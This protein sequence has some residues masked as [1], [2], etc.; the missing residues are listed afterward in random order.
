MTSMTNITTVIPDFAHVSGICDRCANTNANQKYGAKINCDSHDASTQ[1][2][3]KP[4]FCYSCWDLPD[5]NQMN[6]TVRQTTE[7]GEIRRQIGSEQRCCCLEW[8][9]KEIHQYSSS[10]S[11]RC[12]NLTLTAEIQ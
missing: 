10:A 11:K 3:F 5:I 1:K 2:V 7:N 4:P 12:R 8:R 6:H 9:L